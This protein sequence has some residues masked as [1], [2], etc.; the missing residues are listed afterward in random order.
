VEANFDSTVVPARKYSVTET[1]M[2]LSK[3]KRTNKGKTLK[4]CINQVGLDKLENLREKV[5]FSAAQFLF[6]T[7]SL[8]GLSY[9]SLFTLKLNTYDVG[10]DKN[11]HFE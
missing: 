5:V 9:A 1:D 2:L 7:Q 10:F 6:R 3:S 4:L 8:V 11:S